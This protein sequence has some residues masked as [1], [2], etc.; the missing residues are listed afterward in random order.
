MSI[1][2]QTLLS[3]LQIPYDGNL[4]RPTDQTS[5]N[6][7]AGSAYLAYD[8]LTGCGALKA[9]GQFPF[10]YHSPTDLPLPSSIP[11]FEPMSGQTMED[12]IKALAADQNSPFVPAVIDAMEASMT[13][14]RAAYKGGNLKAIHDAVDAINTLRPFTKQPMP[15]VPDADIAM[16]QT[17]PDIRGQFA[18]QC[19]PGQ[20]YF[21][22]LPDPETDA[23]VAAARA[24]TGPASM[25]P[26]VWS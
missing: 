13:A 2:S 1:A 23:V 3:Q 4:G 26:T 18:Q 5:I 24:G 6:Q 10:V 17:T 16:L 8:A 9:G 7:V 22:S 11:G 15:F 20:L 19:G 12:A 25:Q 14:Y 21:P